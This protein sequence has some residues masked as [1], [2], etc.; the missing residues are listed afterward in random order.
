[1]ADEKINERLLEIYKDINSAHFE[2][3][4][5][6]KAFNLK[7]DEEEKLQK[8]EKKVV[9]VESFINVNKPKWRL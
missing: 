3:K 8:E 4:N 1:M 2:V 9:E 6:E 5:M 7:E